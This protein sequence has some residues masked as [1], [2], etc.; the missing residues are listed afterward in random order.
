M[1]DRLPAPA[2]I[3]LFLPSTVDLPEVGPM[4]R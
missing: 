3:G 4:P 2:E 1:A